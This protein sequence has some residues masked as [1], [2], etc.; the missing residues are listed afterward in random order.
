MLN[1]RYCSFVLFKNGLFS[2][3]I[4]VLEIGSIATWEKNVSSP[5]ERIESK[6]KHSV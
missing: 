6:I 3:T 5:A 1:N 4:G 2:K